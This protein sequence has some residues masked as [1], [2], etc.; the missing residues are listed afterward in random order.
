MNVPKPKRY[1]AEIYDVNEFLKLLNLAKDTDLEL[2]IVL[3]GL[4]GLR[5]GECLGLKVNDI[6]FA[7]NTIKINKQLIVINNE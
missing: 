1:R 6:N 5:R 3:A 4:C 7:N 2:P